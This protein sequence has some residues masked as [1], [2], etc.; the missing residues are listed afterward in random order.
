MVSPGKGDGCPEQ[1]ILV[2]V[3]VNA[4]PYLLVEL[5]LNGL[6][7][8][9]I[10]GKCGLANPTDAYNGKHHDVVG[11]TLACLQDLVHQC[12]CVFFDL[13]SDHTQLVELP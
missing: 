10:L 4:Q 8:E 11:D 5:T 13:L 9:D 1:L 3:L 6:V 7:V 12:P 2:E